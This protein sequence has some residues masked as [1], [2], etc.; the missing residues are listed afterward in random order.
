MVRVIHALRQI[1]NTNVNWSTIKLSAYALVDTSL[2]PME[3][4]VLTE[5]NA[6]ITMDTASTYATTVKVL[7][8]VLAIQTTI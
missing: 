3:D 8:L 7:T 2:T 6:F 4:H 1:V 5:M